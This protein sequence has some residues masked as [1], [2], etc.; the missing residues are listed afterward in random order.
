[1]GFPSR[2]TFPVSR[3]DDRCECSH[4]TTGKMTTKIFRLSTIYHGFPV[5]TVN[6]ITKH[7]ITCSSPIQR[8]DHFAILILRFS[9]RLTRPISEIH[10]S[11][12][13]IPNR[14]LPLCWLTRRPQPPY[15]DKI[16]GFQVVYRCVVLILWIAF[17]T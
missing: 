14:C 16:L 9:A 5:S 12:H 4:N 13:Y 7:F 6:K 11:Q 8:T 17:N 1:M 2:K 3:N 15:P 10:L